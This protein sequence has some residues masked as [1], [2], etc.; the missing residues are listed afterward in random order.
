MFCQ[1]DLYPEN[2]LID[3]TGHVVVIDFSEASI[4]PSSFAS[5]CLHYN[6]LEFGV[7]DKV[8]VPTTDG[9]DNTQALLEASNAMTTGWV[10]FES[11]G[12]N[13]KAEWHNSRSDARGGQDEVDMAERTNV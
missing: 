2:F 5:Y 10:V 6:R 12:R 11:L 7:R 13:L 4:V 9:V 3:D 8:R 1:S